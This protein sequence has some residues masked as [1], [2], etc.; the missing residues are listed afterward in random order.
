MYK[1]F[2]MGIA[3]MAALTLVSCSSDDLN[4][5]SDNSSKNEAISFDGYLGRSAVAVNGSRGSVLDNTTLPSKGFGVF[6][7]YS[8][9]TDQTFGSNLF[10]NVKVTGT[11]STGST[12]GTTWTYDPKKYWPTEGHID[13]LAYAPHVDGKTLTGSSS[14]EFTVAKDVT[15]QEDLL[16]AKAVGQTKADNSGANKVKFTFNHALAKIGYSLKEK[17][18]YDK[19][20]ITVTSIK[21]VGSDPKGAFYTKGTID[22]SKENNNEN[23]WTK[24]ETVEKQN[25]DWLSSKTVLTTDVANSNN[26]LFVIPQNFPE[27]ATDKLSVV[28]EYTVQT[29]GT[30]EL[31]NKVTKTI[32]ANF[33]QGKAYMINLIIGLTPIE[34]DATVE[35]WK[36]GA[37][38][39]EIPLN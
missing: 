35:D 14:I 27:S 10:N 36:D 1:K 11:T 22:L 16:W 6:G 19:T 30:E 15:K 33:L 20:T 32:T 3:A 29:E 7:N 2:F 17:E 28:V 39:P 26:Y 37:T 38:I 31:K 18:A 23:L 21:L 8:S 12:G 24:D 4:S 13:F 5:L 25:F 34:F 9:A